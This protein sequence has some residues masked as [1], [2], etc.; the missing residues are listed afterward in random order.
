[1]LGEIWL[2]CKYPQV[3]AY[4]ST[5]L[6]C[7]E[8]MTNNLKKTSLI[9]PGLIQVPYSIDIHH[10][11]S[12]VYTYSTETYQCFSFTKQRKGLLEMTFKD[13]STSRSFGFSLRKRTYKYIYVHQYI[14]PN[15]PLYMYT[16]QTKKGTS[17]N[18]HSSLLVWFWSEVK[19]SVA[20]RL[21]ERKQ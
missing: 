6:K 5:Q 19:S 10:T 20:L 2:Y 1:M 21:N 12:V 14:H 18:S 15:I 11:L 16:S 3:I 13:S 9:S 17:S 8:L 4:Q 7:Q